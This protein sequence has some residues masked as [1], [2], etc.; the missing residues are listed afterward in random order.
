LDCTERRLEVALVQFVVADIAVLPGPE[1]RQQ[2]VGILRQEE[3]FPE[4]DQE[5][6]KRGVAHR[7]E[8]EFL[9]VER[10]RKSPARIHPGG[11]PETASWLL[12]VP[13]FLP[14][15]IRGER[16]LDAFE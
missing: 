8:I 9:A 6:L 15:R 2:I 11:S 1:H 5:I 14:C 7:L 13:A 10:L 4:C 12:D 3:T 16:G